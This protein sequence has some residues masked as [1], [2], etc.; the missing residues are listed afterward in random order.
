[1]QSQTHLPKTTADKARGP[2]STV[3]AG[4]SLSGR[5]SRTSLIGRKLPLSQVIESG[6]SPALFGS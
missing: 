3:A 5:R 4:R 2:L 1:M 6:R